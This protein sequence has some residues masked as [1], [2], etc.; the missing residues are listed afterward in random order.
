[1]T[2]QEML[3]RLERA[4]ADAA[5]YRWL[6]D[7]QDNALHLSR[8]GDHACNY[9]TAKRWIEDMAG[10]DFSEVDPV[11]LE[12]MKETDTIWRLQVYPDT[13]IGFYTW[14]GATLDAAVDAAIAQADQMRRRKE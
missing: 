14:H 1:M 9:V 7:R 10:D 8:N 5:R 12:K 4:E 6:R 13:P 3:E 11:E 2:E